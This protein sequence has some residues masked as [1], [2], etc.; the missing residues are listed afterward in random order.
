MSC[1]ETIRCKMYRRHL[2]VSAWY[3]RHSKLLERI[4][5]LEGSSTLRAYMST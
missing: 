4:C 3:M 2:N 1:V 5:T